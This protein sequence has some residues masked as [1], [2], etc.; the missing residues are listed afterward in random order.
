MYSQRS[1]SL[2]VNGKHVYNAKDKAEA[3]NNQFK[4][5]FCSENLTDMPDCS[6]HPYPCIPDISFSL[7]GVE[8][9]LESIDVKKATSPD[10]ISGQILKLCSAEI[11][12][13]LTVS[14]LIL[15]NFQRNG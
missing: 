1:Y 10:D 11:D 4:S 6:S 3:L 14:H 5:V 8:T 15:V 12:L 7:D 2:N 13:V 9:L